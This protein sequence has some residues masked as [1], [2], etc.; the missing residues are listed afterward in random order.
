MMLG[1]FALAAVVTGGIIF[2]AD[3]IDSPNVKNT[4]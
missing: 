3:H 4:Q 2:A 1:A